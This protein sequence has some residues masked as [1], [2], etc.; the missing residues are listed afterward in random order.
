MKSVSVYSI[1]KKLKNEHVSLVN[2]DGYWYYVYDDEE[3]GIF[4]T[5]S[6]Y[7]MYLNSMTVADWVEIGKDFIKKVEA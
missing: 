2:G 7:V 4:A 6:V 1:I 5:E 3:R